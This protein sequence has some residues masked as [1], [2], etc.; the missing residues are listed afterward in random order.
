MLADT[1]NRNFYI[2]RARAICLMSGLSIPFTTETFKELL[3]INVVTRTQG[4]ECVDKH[5]TLTAFNGTS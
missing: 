4:L 2:A 5:S 3:P 1:Y